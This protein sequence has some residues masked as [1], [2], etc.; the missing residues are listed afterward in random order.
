MFITFLRI[1]FSM[2]ICSLAECVLTSSSTSDCF[3]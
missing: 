2:N 3:I 1:R